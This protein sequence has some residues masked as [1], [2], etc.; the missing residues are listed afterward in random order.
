MKD[1]VV[2]V[3]IFHTISAI[4]L[5]AMMAVTVVGVISQRFHPKD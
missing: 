3:S 5:F 2:A 1:V 4:A